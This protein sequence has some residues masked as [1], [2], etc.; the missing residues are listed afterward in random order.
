MS[1]SVESELKRLIDDFLDA[2]SFTPGQR[3]R[4]E[5]IRELFVPEGHLIKASEQPPDIS[6]PEQFIAPRQ[7]MVD[8]GR[9]TS[10]RESELHST[11]E[12]FGNIAHRLSMYEK[13]GVMSGAAFQAIGVIS[14]QFILTSRGWKMSSMAWDDERPGL[15]LADR[16]SRTSTPVLGAATDPDVGL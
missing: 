12:V 9:L 14:A 11:T 10:F 5:R 16:F 4:Y 13:T 7:H 8:M 15:S 6:T 1:Q 2:V 3:P